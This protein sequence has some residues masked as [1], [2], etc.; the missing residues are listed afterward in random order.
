[1]NVDETSGRI[2]F[3][4]LVSATR[5]LGS[6]EAITCASAEVAVA[7]NAKG[8]FAHKTPIEIHTAAKTAAA[9]LRETLTS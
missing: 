9:K 3:D 2:T 7:A 5:D 8:V 4:R 6:A 1:M